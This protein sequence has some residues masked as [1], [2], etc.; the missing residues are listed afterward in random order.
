MMGSRVQ[1]GEDE[2]GPSNLPFEQSWLRGTERGKG[3]RGK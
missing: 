1:G 2:D 3:G